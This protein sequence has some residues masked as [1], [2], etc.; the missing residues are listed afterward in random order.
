MFDLARRELTERRPVE[1]REDEVPTDGV[2]LGVRHHDEREHLD[3][4]PGVGQQVHLLGGRD[5]LVPGDGNAA[6]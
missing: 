3:G 4:S 2:A 5:P 6:V 1:L